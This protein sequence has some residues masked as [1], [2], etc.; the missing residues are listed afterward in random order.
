M[1]LGGGD[2]QEFAVVSPDKI[3]HRLKYQDL[4]SNE[5]EI[6]HRLQ[7]NSLDLNGIKIC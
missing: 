3:C 4:D 7:Y 1:V 5:F 6:C 2:D